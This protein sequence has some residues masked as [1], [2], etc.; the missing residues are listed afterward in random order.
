[1]ALARHQRPLALAHFFRAL[2]AKLWA[3]S[4]VGPR[5]VKVLNRSSN[6]QVEE[7]LE[8]IRAKTRE[9]LATEGHSLRFARQE[10]KDVTVGD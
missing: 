3:A 7:V 5:F 1:M 2:L 9:C 4:R 8:I 6:P 10:K